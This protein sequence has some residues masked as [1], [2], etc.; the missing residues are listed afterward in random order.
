MSNLINNLL[1]NEKT[2]ATNASS[3]NTD[4]SVKDK[5]SLFDS[6]LSNNG[7]TEETKVNTEVKQEIK[8]VKVE[9]PAVVNDKEIKADNKKVDELSTEQ[10][11]IVEEADNKG[12]KS[13]G[14]SSLLD[15]LILEAKNSAKEVVPILNEE[16]NKIE[17]N[18]L[19]T[20]ETKTDVDIN[21]EI[22]PEEIKINTE[23]TSEIKPEEI[24]VNTEETSEIKPTETKVNTKEVKINENIVDN[25]S[26]EQ[27]KVTKE[28]DVPV[29]KEA[30]TTSLLDRLI[31]DVKNEVKE[32]K[33]EEIP[34]INSEEVKE[35]E[36]KLDI[37][38]S[39]IK[40][41]KISV[42]DLLEKTD[43]K[44]ENITV[45][46]ED[47]TKKVNDVLNNG[48]VETETTSLLDNI[49]K[50]VEENFVDSKVENIATASE[51]IDKSIN[52]NLGIVNNSPILT[53]EVIPDTN[54]EKIENIDVKKDV[55][56]SLMDQLI[57]KNSEKLTL[58]NIN[59]IKEDI[60][61]PF[62]DVVTKDLISNIYL[63]SQKNK[64]T[65]QNLFNQ[66]EAISLLKD[67]NSIQA[68]K[69]SA[70]MLDLG[71]ESINV[72]QDI[73]TMNID[74]KKSNIDLLNRKNLI[75]NLL[76]K[77]DIRGEEVKDLITKSV[78]ASNAL[79][80][81]TLT[82][83]DD[84]TVNVNSP[85]S[86]NIQSRIIGAKQQMSAMMSDI[87]KQMYEN[88]KPPVTAF[89]INLN[90]LD[91]GSIAILMKNDKQNGLTISMNV[92]NTITLDTLIENQNVL[93][94]SLNKTFDENTK[95][96]LDFSSSNQ[97]N[98]NQS[99]NN[100]QGNNRQFEQQM[101]TRSILQL[102]EENKDREEKVID[103][104]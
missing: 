43:T 47:E 30:E 58:D 18:S 48:I 92:S 41:E 13:T 100:G 101:D 82:V 99:S 66:N 10:S 5:P 80:D 81:N 34:I 72:E 93:K 75:D 69:T 79:I 38:K 55:K 96:N 3:I 59:G 9:D 62:K 95:F 83:A 60:N 25:L 35:E 70:E 98:S 89:K 27:L 1:T 51:I 84:V 49:S 19:T 73:E 86:Y 32:A 97:N 8:E 24:K 11:L 40:E 85:L 7:T 4:Q 71:L 74:V 6:L 29:Q 14:T 61:T 56:I 64:I 39:K 91:L 102:Q 65:N 57:Q 103:Y 45:I 16:V 12:Q 20:E 2:T 63:G 22:K 23:E 78:V 44:V 21:S 52:T 50:K 76:F 42:I 67:G 46:N 87:A 88:Y 94:N 17:N 15:R 28:I 90:P 54:V 37:K 33:Q 104:M 31:L 26:T 53:S 68:V 77:N 36:N